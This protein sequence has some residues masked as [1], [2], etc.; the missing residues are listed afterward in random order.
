[1]RTPV[2]TVS[3]DA[4]INR[5]AKLM[6]ENNISSLVVINGTSLNIMT[7]SDLV[8]L[9]AEHLRHKRPLDL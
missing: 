7:K 9:Y 1:M 2:L 3:F 6:I 4:S 5:C 8:K